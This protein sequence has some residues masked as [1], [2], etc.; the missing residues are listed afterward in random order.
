MYRTKNLLHYV[1]LG[2]YSLL[3]CFRNCVRRNF[4]LSSREN[5]GR[6]LST[7][8]IFTQRDPWIWDR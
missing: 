5:T 8:E 6:D 7:V 3:H 4:R 2:P 1:I